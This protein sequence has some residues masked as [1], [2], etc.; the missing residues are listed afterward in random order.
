MALY[1]HQLRLCAGKYAELKKLLTQIIQRID[2]LLIST[3]VNNK[4]HIHFFSDNI[5][6]IDKR[7][8]NTEN[9]IAFVLLPSQ[10]PSS[11]QSLPKR[12]EFQLYGVFLDF[13]FP[14][15]D[16]GFTSGWCEW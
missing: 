5:F 8:V 9:L 11:L 3:V 16:V 15:S 4:V 6:I 2:Q 10:V 1:L 12:F 14:I 13:L 7:I